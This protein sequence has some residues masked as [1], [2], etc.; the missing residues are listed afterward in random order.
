MK[1]LWKNRLI[2]RI[3]AIVLFTAL[4]GFSPH[5]H[6]VERAL[7]QAERAQTFEAHLHAARNLAT[8]AMHIQWLT[9]LWEPAG[10]EALAGGAPL[11]AID[12][13]KFAAA[14]GELSQSGY[15]QFGDA[16]QAIGNPYT[17]IQLWS[18][19]NHIFGSSSPAF[20]RIA[21]QQRVLK[22]YPALIITLKEIAQVRGSQ[23]ITKTA[24]ADQNYELGLLLAAVD[25]AA[26]P[27]YLIQ[28]AE[29]NPGLTPAS[30]LAFAIQRALPSANPA[31]TR[32][33][34]GRKLASLG[35]WDL[36]AYAFKMVT[37]THPEYSEG[38]AYL[39]EAH[40]HLAGSE[41]QDAINALQ[42]A[43]AL[44]PTSL[45]ANILMA[46]Y[47]QRD[48]S[49]ER[50]QPFLVAALQLDPSNPDILV[51]LGAAT[52][53][54]G[55]L[56]A[57]AAYYS[58]AIEITNA[59]PVYLRALGEFCIRYNHNIE[60]VALLAARQALLSNP[61]NPGSLD[62]MGQVLFR[63]G[64]LLNAQ[65]F[66]LRAIAINPGYGPAYL[67]HG[68]ILDMQG[69][70]HLAIQS[71]QRAISLATDTATVALAARYLEEISQP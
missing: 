64:D 69:E 11:L 63:M 43:I 18:T 25:P 34:A 70:P 24:L 41:P 3:L 35:F 21:S 30:Q 10:R 14:A 23:T 67:H 19:S 60:S 40:Q 56:E 49:P 29:L 8:A 15:I 52:A 61:H 1:D 50:A 17:A 71:Y 6:L 27:P 54:L 39:G 22:D 65:R 55:D 2:P 16:C 42:T 44:D 32:M 51:D 13:F 12:Y 38:W 4:L 66:L 9:H 37:Q 20:G 46:V 58:D 28:A 68:L 59:N 47:W 31:F 26:A 57:A 48:G 45:S 5:P 62:L 53:A 33:A 36:A 7:I